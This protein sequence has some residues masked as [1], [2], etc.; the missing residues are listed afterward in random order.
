MWGGWQR[1]WKREEETGGDGDADARDA[2][3][4]LRTIDGSCGGW[5]RAMSQICCPAALR[6]PSLVPVVVL[7]REGAREGMR[8]S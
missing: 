3:R 7:C 2:R 1:E 6:V 8:A 5:A 4:T